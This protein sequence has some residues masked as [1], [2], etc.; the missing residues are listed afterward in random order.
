M[1]DEAAAFDHAGRRLKLQRSSKMMTKRRRGTRN[2]CDERR[3]ITGVFA[4]IWIFRSRVTAISKKILLRDARVDR[5]NNVGDGAC[6][7]KRSRVLF[8]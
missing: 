5:W 8:P 6:E 3:S 7:Q 4:R 1:L 2:A